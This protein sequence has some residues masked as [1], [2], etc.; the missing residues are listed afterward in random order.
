MCDH[1]VTEGLNDD[2][3][4]C[5]VIQRTGGGERQCKKMLNDHTDLVEFRLKKNLW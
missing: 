5:Y 3:W 2:F 4:N 1:V